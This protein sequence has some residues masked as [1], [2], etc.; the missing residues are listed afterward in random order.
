METKKEITYKEFKNAVETVEQYKKQVS[1]KFEQMKKDL[2]NKDFSIYLIT[3]DTKICN[4]KLSVR[5]YNS[6]KYSKL[7]QIEGLRFSYNENDCEVTVG[8]FE[9]LKKQD[10]LNIRNMGKKTRNEL[11]RMFFSAGIELL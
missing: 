5:A 9:G 7:K 1:G 2:D 4:A 10:L 8:S 11:E 6:L 3:K